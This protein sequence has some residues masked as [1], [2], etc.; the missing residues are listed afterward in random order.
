MTN[1]FNR[2]EIL[3]TTLGT[4]L[5]AMIPGQASSE[6]LKYA[7]LAIGD[8]NHVSLSRHGNVKEDNF[9]LWSILTVNN[10]SKFLQQLDNILEKQ[11]YRSEIT[12]HSNDKFKLAACRDIIDLVMSYGDITFEMKFFENSPSS[13]KELKPTAFE[14]KIGMLY[15]PVLDGV[16]STKMISKA[17][18]NYGPSAQYNKRFSEKFGL[19]NVAIN[20]IEDRILQIN[21]LCAGIC[22]ALLTKREVKSSVKVEL[23]NHFNDKLQISKYINE[24]Q[25]N[26]PPFNI[27]KE[28]I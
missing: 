22:Y 16:K 26:L 13:F 19:D 12:Y 25:I 28:K 10:P 3:K 15:R 23:N 20:P 11:K 14:E 8:D 21:N 24:S 7:D 9:L 4:A 18:D 6:V 27:T 1:K 5:V 2:R 17:E